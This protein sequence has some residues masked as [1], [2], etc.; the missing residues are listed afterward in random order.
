MGKILQK[1]SI[2]PI[3]PFDPAKDYNIEFIYHD[4]QAVKN[5]AVITLNDEKGE[6]VY[7]ETVE[8]MALLHPL[9]ANT[10]AAGNKY[11][12]KIQ[13]FDSGNNS[14]DFSESVLFS[15]LTTP[16]FKFENLENDSVYKQA[17]IT[18]QLK[19]EQE[20][21]EQLKNYQ[22]IQ[23]DGSKVEIASSDV[24][25][26]KENLTHTFYG[27]E[28][29]NTYYFRAIGETQNGMPLDTGYVGINVELVTLPIDAIFELE[30]DYWN[31]VVR[32]LFNIKD[33]RYELT[34][35]EDYTF[36][37]GMVTLNN[38]SLIY[39]EGFEATYDFTL[40][41]QA[42]KVSLGTFLD[43]E[44]GAIQLSTLKI[45]DSY[46]C[47][48]KIKDSDFRQYV[49]LEGA[50]IT[51]DGQLLLTSNN[52]YVTFIIKRLSGYYGLELV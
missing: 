48:L 46:Y 52:T 29:N 18:L 49:T 32:L 26:E 6:V 25:Y 36:S 28:N 39:N 30:N 31:G 20:E 50:T 13:V 43:M 23:Y 34:G 3:I 33:V 12:V 15:C 5:R 14:S 45:C 11:L 37:N 17:N 24:M 4:N 2:L 21:N 35:D 40:F 8:S 47:E 7:N 22:I 51:D 44:N 41:C 42:N 9:P 1:P 19:Y 10:L 27:L 38:T 16:E